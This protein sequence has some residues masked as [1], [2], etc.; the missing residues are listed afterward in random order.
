MGG[1]IDDGL[2]LTIRAWVF[3]ALRARPLSTDHLK[4]RH[5]T[6]ESRQ[7][8][9]DMSSDGRS[10]MKRMKR[11]RPIIDPCGTPDLFT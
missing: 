5:E 11:R 1:K 7:H 3:P 9:N 6:P 10:L 4:N 8:I 2:A